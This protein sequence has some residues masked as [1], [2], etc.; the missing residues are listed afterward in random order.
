MPRAR[1]G[2]STEAVVAAA[3]EL[4]DTDGLGALS[5]STLA[6]RLGVRT[7]SLYNHVAGLGGLRTLLALHGIE[8]LA[9]SLRTATMGRSRDD[10]VRHL[11]SAYRRFAHEHPGLYPLTQEAHP[12]DPAFDE[13]SRRAIEPVLAALA[14][15]GID[16]DDAIHATRALRSALHGFVSLEAGGGFGIDLDPAD[17][18]TRLV[19]VLVSALGSW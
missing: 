5:L 7:P 4:V 11:A 3:A 2:L 19:D 17:S 12:D 6:D 15:F 9:E 8:L 1:A 16:G 13:S 14:G 18:F 10:A